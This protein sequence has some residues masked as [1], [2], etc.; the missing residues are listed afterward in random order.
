M[1]RFSDRVALVTG[2]SSGIGR[3][4]ALRLAHEGAAVALVALP[5]DELAAA[6]QECRAT[7]SAALAVPTDVADSC[8]VAAA[9]EQAEALGP[10][11]AVF[12]NAGISI[13]G[14]VTEMDDDDWLRQLHINLSGSFY[15]LRAGARRMGPLG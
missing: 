2:A 14:P 8:Q 6:T 9:F 3:A 11:D 10:V 4:A 7:G 12:S 13:V 1:P 15:M 5:G